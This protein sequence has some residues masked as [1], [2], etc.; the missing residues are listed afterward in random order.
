MMGRSDDRLA[1]LESKLKDF[2]GSAATELAYAGDRFDII[3]EMENAVVRMIDK[4]NPVT[5]NMQ[6]HVFS[7]PVSI[8]AD[9]VFFQFI[10]ETLLSQLFHTIQQGIPVSIHISKTG[11]RG[12]VEIKESYLPAV[13]AD[14]RLHTDPSLIACNQLMEDMGGELLYLP[15]EKGNYFRLK[16]LLC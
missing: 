9:K 11:E 2:E 12:I 13:T 15:N 8:V 3:P 6:V 16:F 5:S 4:A 7:S 10:I 1:Y 14:T